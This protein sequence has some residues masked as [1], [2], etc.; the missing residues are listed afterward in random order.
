MKYEILFSANAKND[1]ISIVRYISVELSEPEIAEK[2]SQRML[3]AIKSLEEF[4][5]RYRL[6]D[7][8]EWKEKGLRVVPVEN[9]LVFYITDAVKRCVKIYR[10]LYGKRDTEKQLKERITFEE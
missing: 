3:K 7:F 6:C 8:V 5:N 10:I 9:Y 1:L 2:V 4:P